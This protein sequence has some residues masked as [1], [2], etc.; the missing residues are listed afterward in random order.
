MES[1]TAATSHDALVI[2]GNGPGEVAGW[3]VPIAAEARRWAR[4][5]GRALAVHLC[6][7]PCQFASGQEPAAAA[8]AGVF[9]AIVEPRA[10]LRLG[11]GLGTWTPG[12]RVAVLHVGGDFWYSRRLARRW[13]ARAFAFVERAH[14]ARQHRAYERIFVP[15]DAVAQRLLRRGVPDAKVTVTGDP[16]RDALEEVRDRHVPPNGQGPG[17]RVAFLAGS[18]DMV[19]SAFFPFWVETA[20][21]L[22]AELPDVQP[23]IVISP[24]VSSEVRDALVARYRARLDAVGVR[25]DATGWPGIVGADLVLTLPGT[26]TLE[27]A[28]LR[29]PSIVVLPTTFS[30]QIPAEGAI[31]WL[32]R[33][34]GVGPALKLFLARQYLRR[35]PYVA[36]PNMWARRRI[37]P[38]LIGAVT[39][40]EVAAEAAR[41]LRDPAARRALAEALAVIPAQAGASRRIV[42]TLRPVWEAA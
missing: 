20:A 36:L 31:E 13:G 37:M 42:E 39:P 10:T 11:L 24:F 27:L 41:L 7:P 19:F 6:L 26:N 3:A 1:V 18:R 33:I 29:M 32:S 23:V 38:E 15:T 2:V 25:V 8:A 14:I 21:V 28:I 34:P 30:V 5:A 35:A 17:L 22:R 9:D 12:A 16:R 4:A 40:V